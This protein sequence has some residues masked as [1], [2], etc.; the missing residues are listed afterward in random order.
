LSVADS[1]KIVVQPPA[2]ASTRRHRVVIVGGGFGGLRAAKALVTAPVEITLIDRTNHHLFQPLL[3]QVA[4]GVLSPGQIAPALRSLF[5]G[6]RN[7]NVLLG[8]V[9]GIDLERRVVRTASTGER[10]VPYDTLIVA[11]GASHSYFGRDHW[12]KFAPGMKTL[13]D[14][15]VLRSRILLAFEMA[16]QEPDPTRRAAWLTFAIV[17]AGPTGVEL[18]GQIALLAHRVLRHEYR[19]A[20]PRQARVVLLDG[21][22]RVLGTFAPRLSERARNALEDLGV[23]VTLKSEVVDIDGD[24]VVVSDG[25][26]HTQRI[27]ARTVVWAAGVQASPLGAQLAARC[28]A[29]LDR[30]GRLHVAPDLSLPGRPE[31][32]AIG[33]MISLPGVPGTAQPA[34]Q[35]GKYVAQVIRARLR[36]EARP[37]SFA[38][39]D[40][41]SMAMIGRNQAVAE[42]F[43]RVGLWGLPAFLAWGAIHLAYLVGWGSRVET[44]ARWGWTLL[45]RNRRERLISLTGL[46]GAESIVRELEQTLGT[47]MDGHDSRSEPFEAAR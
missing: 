47:S 24:G 5:R 19:R 25:I 8:D 40:L 13:D 11:A 16:D 41:G 17:G 30:A 28:G 7:V 31:V 14:A 33:D 29:E 32:F 36:G 45:A 35:Q 10:E 39:R 15:A 34:I 18:A 21:A 9:A 42:L 27:G 12:A 37:P 46:A 6:N 3:Y 23:A 1:A 43:A 38:Y 2:R 44:V 22:P 20:E 26:G 4:T